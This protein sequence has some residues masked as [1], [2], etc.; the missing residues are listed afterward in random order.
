MTHKNPNLQLQEELAES[1][2][3]EIDKD[4]EQLR[5]ESFRETLARLFSLTED[6]ASHDEIRAR[7]LDGGKFTGTNMIVL[8]LAIFIASAGLNTNSTAVIIGAMLISPLMGN[9][10]AMAYGTASVDKHIFGQFSIGFVAKIFISIAVS[11]LYFALSP[12]KTPT[13][14][15]I[16]RTSPG[17]TDVI[18]AICGGLAGIVGQTRKD[19]ANNIIPGVAIATALMPPLCT[20]GYAI[21]NWRPDMLIHAFYLFS[22]NAYFIF[23]SSTWV[24]SILQVPHVGS[25]SEK[26]WM[27]IRWR[28]FR[29]AAL[30]TIPTI[31]AGFFLAAGA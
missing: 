1:T 17:F 26:Q 4:I 3:E 29:N 23:L 2:K 8:I 7:I 19:K 24:L 6:V 16:A 11:T 28:M 18:I 5:Q 20:C 12:I 15:L 22:V 14:E 10:L 30:I 13:A 27:A 9:I 21:A 25:L 31:A